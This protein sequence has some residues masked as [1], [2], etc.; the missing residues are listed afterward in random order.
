MLLDIALVAIGIIAI[1]TGYNRGA[2]ATLFS[3]I[4]YF[5]GGVAGFAAANWYRKPMPIHKER[6]K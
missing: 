3:I 6:M 4:G 1:A 5:G 2:L